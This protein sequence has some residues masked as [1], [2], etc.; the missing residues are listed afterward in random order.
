[1]PE[2]MEKRL[3]YYTGQ[4]LQENDF[5]DEQHYH[6]DRQRRHNRLLHTPGIAEG[7]IVTGSPGDSEVNVQPGTAIDA[8]GH[9][10]VLAG[11]EI[12][13]WTNDFHN[14]EVFVVISYEE[15]ATDLATEGVREE[16][17][18]HERPRLQVI[19]IDDPDKPANTFIRLARLSID[20]SGELQATPPETPDLSVR[21]FAGGRLGS[22]VEL[23]KLT[24]TYTTDP[25]NSPSF[26]AGDD[27]RADLQ[28][29]LQID[30]NLDVV[31]GTIQGNL[32]N[33]SVRTADLRNL[34][35]TEAKLAD[36][37]VTEA[38]LA[39]N[40]VSQA[41]IQDGSINSAKLA[42]NAV[43]LNQLADNS[44]NGFKIVN[45]SIG[46]SELAN[47][48]VNQVKLSNNSVNAAK[49]QNG[50]VGTAEL[51][52]GAVTQV[53][54]AN[55]SVNAAKIQNGTVGTVELANGAVT[56]EKLVNNSVTQDK[57]D[58]STRTRVDR[59]LQDT[60]DTATGTININIDVSPSSGP[61]VTGPIGPGPITGP[62]P[63]VTTPIVITTTYGVNSRVR[64]NGNGT[65]YGVYGRSEGG[66]SGSRFGVYGFARDGQ[67]RYGVYGNVSGGGYAG[68]FSGNVRV[69]GT[70]TKTS[71]NFLIDHPLD[72]LNKT[73]RHGFVE[74]PENLCL[75]RGKVRLDDRGEAIVTMPSYF[76]A[77]TKEE[78][79][80]VTLTPIG[81]KPFLVSYEWNPDYTALRVFGMA[82]AEVSYLVM[83][84]RDD[85]AILQHRQPVEQ[86]KGNGNFEK[87]KL[88]NPEAYGYPK[89]M[90]VDYENEIEPQME[91][92][93]S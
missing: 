64:G 27:N 74:S 7:L 91:E 39:D 76:A 88:L 84:D 81:R 82:N 33:N 92:V 44:V 32:A 59:A 31:N 77:L 2:D 65:K 61:I 68:Y 79:A 12:V 45:E 17:R 16:T 13:T 50:T 48:A 22:E 5:N 40:S 19:A 86:E 67:N 80:T 63:I 28:G 62:G 1:M 66:D 24:L 20:S 21:S 43:T 46:T 69:N 36:G 57:L 90:G 73:L 70:L 35:V 14:R 42:N 83:A 11:N 29:S 71:G 58:S 78:E 34:S 10:I 51:A 56:T 38:K 93:L 87:G 49:I 55:N 37:A 18:W 60:G 8:E 26:T 54:L 6:L 30:G 75:Y 9:A 3:R 15:E 52:N 85:P 25:R 53:K 4:F 23:D 72:P 89:T 47:G 41:K